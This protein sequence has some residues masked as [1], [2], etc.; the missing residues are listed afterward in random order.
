MALT[1]HKKK[2]AAGIGFT[3]LQD[4]RFKTNY[5]SLRLIVP[6]NKETAAKNAAVSIVLSKSCRKYPGLT[7]LNRKLSALYGAD[8]TG[9]VSKTG[10]WQVVSL[11]A[12]CI[13]DAYTFDREAITAELTE[14]LL[15][16]VLNPV[17]N[18]AGDAFEEKAFALSRQELL[19]A[20]DAEINEK[21]SY[22]IM[23]ALERIYI[24]EPAAVPAN[25]YREQAEALTA[26]E[27][28]GQYR[29]LL[30]EARIE[31]IFS[32]GGNPALPEQK[33]TE[34]LLSLERAYVPLPATVKSPIPEGV[35]ETERQLD[36]L[37]N[38]LVMAFKT[39]EENVPALKVA[40]AIF[41]GIPTSKL[42]ANV[43][44]KL[45]LCYYCASSLDHTK[46]VLLVDS[47]VEQ[48]NVLKARAEIAA[49]LKALQTGDFTD[50]EQ[51]NAVL[52]LVNGLR[53]VKDSP[54]AL[55]GWYFRQ[56][57]QETNRTPEEEIQRVQAVS[58]EDVIQAAS[59]MQLSNVYLLTQNKAGST[60][61]EA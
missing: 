17:L 29:R 11:S 21:R 52:S 27:V 7:L 42:F 56:I 31:A 48:S 9:F 2:I 47:G 55:A 59:S 50:E 43:R 14:I 22:A 51:N 49:Q 6:L 26:K 19:D 46:G 8:L 39:H 60:A 41:G 38:K 1:F 53:A 35:R 25:G 45:S 61:K 34:A 58:R 40:N 54:Y 20:I 18:E 4:P 10:D 3:A 15:D 30:S 37:Q 16:C 13:D 36:V 5:V 23:S 57:L 32:G 28:Y 24:G 33:I 12:H 44:E